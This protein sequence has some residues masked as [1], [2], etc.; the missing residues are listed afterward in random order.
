MI[1]L[2]WL[3]EQERHGSIFNTQ[4]KDFLKKEREEFPL[5]VALFSLRSK[6]HSLL[7]ERHTE[8][9]KENLCKERSQVDSVIFFPS[10]IL[11]HSLAKKVQ[12]NLAG[13]F[14]D[15]LV[16]HDIPKF[17]NLFKAFLRKKSSWY[18]IRSSV[19]MNMNFILFFFFIL[20]RT[21]Y[22]NHS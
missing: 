4:S 12:I 19:S 11:L 6:W 7:A 16:G 21:L 14:W 5:F 15:L 10:L 20:K 13:P 8:K 9:K 1:I 3:V 22:P 18:W 17:F 2:S